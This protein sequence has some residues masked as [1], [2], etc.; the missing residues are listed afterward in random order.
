MLI[1]CNFDKLSYYG[2]YRF[3]RF[4]PGEF[5][6]GKQLG[7]QGLEAL[8]AKLWLLLQ[9]L[10]RGLRVVAE[11]DGNGPWGE[12]CRIISIIFLNISL[13]RKIR[14]L[15]LRFYLKQHIR[16]HVET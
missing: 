7:D 14:S 8:K 9:F 6:S 2:P 3:F 11:E 15:I 5:S 4:L 12:M 13:I 16:S 1:V 10:Q